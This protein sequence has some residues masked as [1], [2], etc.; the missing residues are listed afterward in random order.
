VLEG[1]VLNGFKCHKVEPERQGYSSR[2]VRESFLFLFSA[3]IA[4]LI[5][6]KKSSGMNP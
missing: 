5:R 6:L 1:K 4:A 3:T 2:G